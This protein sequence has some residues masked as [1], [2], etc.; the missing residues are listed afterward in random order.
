M[1]KTNHFL[2]QNIQPISPQSFT[3][4]GGFV[5]LFSDIEGNEIVGSGKY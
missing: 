1:F 4:F 5:V 2:L 3:N